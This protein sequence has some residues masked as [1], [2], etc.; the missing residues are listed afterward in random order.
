MTAA[1]V[2]SGELP[3]GPFYQGTYFNEP[4]TGQETG[5]EVSF[6]HSD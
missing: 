6:K 1:E 3:S 4:N 2:V 5:S